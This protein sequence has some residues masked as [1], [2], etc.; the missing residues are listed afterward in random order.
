MREESF[1]MV[2]FCD[3][4]ADGP[5]TK[6]VDTGIRGVKYERNLFNVAFFNKPIKYGVIFC[7]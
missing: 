5:Q 7:H 6:T 2:L 3:K 1:D 4:V